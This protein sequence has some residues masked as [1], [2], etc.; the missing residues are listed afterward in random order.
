MDVYMFQAA[1]ICED[2]TQKVKSSVKVP[3][4][5]GIEET[6]DSDNYPK[7]PYPDGGGEADS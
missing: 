1:F 3:A 4:K 2:C 7:G 5:P 6:Y